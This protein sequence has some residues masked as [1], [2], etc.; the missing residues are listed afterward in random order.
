MDRDMFF[1]FAHGIR[2]TLESLGLPFDGD[3]MLP[4]LKRMESIV[5]S[6]KHSLVKGDDSMTDW[7][8]FYHLRAIEQQLCVEYLKKVNENA[9]SAADEAPDAEDE[10]GTTTN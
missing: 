3:A 8:R 5:G 2:M 9:Q 10:N 6:P 7:N 4:V 1:A